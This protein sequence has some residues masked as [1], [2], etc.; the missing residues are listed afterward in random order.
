[1]R[2]LLFLLLSTSLLATPDL[3]AARETY[4]RALTDVSFIKGVTATGSMKPSFDE[5]YYILVVPR[6]VYPFSSLKVDDVVLVWMMIDGEL[7]YV[8][9]RVWRVSSGGSIIL[10]K[11][12]AN[13][14]PDPVNLT[15]QDY[16]GLVVGWV[17]N[18]IKPPEPKPVV[19]V[20][21]VLDEKAKD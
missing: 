20:R 12:D 18:D 6:T 21:F 16:V 15:E 2:T 14:R 4:V 5:N 10:T 17:R 9:H 3:N 7:G 11:G 1:M 13:S 19:P 8:C